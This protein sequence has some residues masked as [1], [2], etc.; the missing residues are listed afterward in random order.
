VKTGFSYEE[1]LE[2]A[3]QTNKQNLQYLSNN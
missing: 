2:P 3:Q 1:C